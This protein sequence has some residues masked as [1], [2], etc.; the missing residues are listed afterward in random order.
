MLATSKDW[1]EF[2]GYKD[3]FVEYRARDFYGPFLEMRIRQYEKGRIEVIPF[4]SKVES[5]EFSENHLS[6][7]SKAT[8]ELYRELGKFI[9]KTRFFDVTI[10]SERTKALLLKELMK[11]KL[12]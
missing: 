3:K 9:L 8:K 11:L 1:V 6:L 4:N 10:D 12:F 5:A 7:L 2:Y